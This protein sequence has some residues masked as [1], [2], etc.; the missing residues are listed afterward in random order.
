MPE[1][2]VVA[3]EQRQPVAHHLQ[4]PIDLGTGPAQ[5]VTRPAREPAWC[6]RRGVAAA[7]PAR[8]NGLELLR[9]DQ[10]HLTAGVVRTELAAVDGVTS[11]RISAIERALELVPILAV[12]REQRKDQLRIDQAAAIDLGLAT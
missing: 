12:A 5:V 3:A 11:R 4:S 2:P 9:I 8:I 6:R 1:L 7:T 10:V